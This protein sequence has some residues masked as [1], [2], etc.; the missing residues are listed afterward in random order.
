MP[1]NKFANEKRAAAALIALKA[2]VVAST[3]EIPAEIN[4]GHGTMQRIAQSVDLTEAPED[5][6][7]SL[8]IDLMHC[9][10]RE[11]IDW[12]RDVMSRA[13]EHFRSERAYKVQKR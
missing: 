5:A 8:V 3:P 2:H 9:C 1:I 13:W 4:E 12:T 10:E 11:K 7:C 6:L